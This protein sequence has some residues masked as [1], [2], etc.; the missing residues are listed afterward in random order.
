MGRTIPSSFR[1]ALATW[2]KGNRRSH[3]AMP[4][5]RQIGV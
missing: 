1:I 5:I 4:W 3:L 2:K